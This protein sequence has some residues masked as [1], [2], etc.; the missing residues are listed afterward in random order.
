ME[1]LLILV[2]LGAVVAALTAIVIIGRWILGPIDR[3]AKDREAAVRFSIGDFLC[4][5]LTVQIPL[6]L[7]YRFVNDEEKPLF[8]LFTIITWIIAPLVWFACARA[9]SK[10][11]IT[12]GRP[13]MVFLGVIVPFVYYGLLPFLFLTL[14]GAVVLAQQVSIYLDGFGWSIAGRVPQGAVASSGRIGWYVVAWFLLAS[15]FYITGLFT[16]SMVR[17]ARGDEMLLTEWE[18]QLE[19]ARAAVSSIPDANSASVPVSEQ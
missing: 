9:L 18:R 19:L 7:I 15:G 11:G 1:L 6:S 8:W 14:A 10:A 12:A 2:P 13:R 17:H 4:L 5:F 3:A 16:R